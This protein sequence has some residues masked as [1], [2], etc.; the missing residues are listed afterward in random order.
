MRTE[1]RT[2][3][4]A[5]KHYEAYSSFCSFVRYD[6][7]FSQNHLFTL[8]FSLRGPRMLEPLAKKLM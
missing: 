7:T 8:N 3:S 2:D 5:E 4:Q 6:A 1:G